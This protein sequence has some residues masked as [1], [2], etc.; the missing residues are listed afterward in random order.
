MPGPEHGPS[1]ESHPPGERS[2]KPSR[3]SRRS[4]GGAS[5][6]PR[7][8]ASGD[9][10][11]RRRAR[12]SAA[13]TRRLTATA[14]AGPSGTADRGPGQ[15]PGGHG[16]PGAGRRAC[17][18]SPERAGLVSLLELSRNDHAAWRAG[19]ILDTSFNRRQTIRGRREADPRNL[20][21]NGKLGQRLTPTEDEAATARP[22]GAALSPRGV[23]TRPARAVAG[24][25][26]SARA[27]LERDL[28]NSRRSPKR[29]PYKSAAF[30]F[31]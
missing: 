12:A 13:M 25:R 6:R 22:R 20:G 11:F 2:V 9:G 28:Q 23:S 4:R 15:A 19:F 14:A 5:R 10:R 21:R 16:A 3:Q 30:V 24:W 31:C 17:P 1:R 8:P 7:H 27:A 18:R 29:A 26:R